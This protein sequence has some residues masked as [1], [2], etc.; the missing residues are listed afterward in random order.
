MSRAARTGLS[1]VVAGAAMVAGCG[2]EEPPL[3]TRSEQRLLERLADARG[4]VAR[5]ELVD[6][7]A[8]FATFEGDVARLEDKGALT[9]EQASPL[10]TG[11]RRARAVLAARIRERERAAAEAARGAS[12][13]PSSEV[14][15][16]REDAKDEEREE[17][18]GRKEEAREE[19]EE[20]REE[21]REEAEGEE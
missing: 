16:A 15:P 7:R 8:A 20:R 12:P 4:A 11:A 2:A 19:R 3:T 1:V 21:K 17:L 18:D 13:A 5:G 10:L 9:V 14:D 6:A